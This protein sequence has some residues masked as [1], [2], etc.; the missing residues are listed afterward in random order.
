MAREHRRHHGQPAATSWKMRLAA[1]AGIAVTAGAAAFGVSR[2]VG[3]GVAAG[4]GVGWFGGYAF[5]ELSHWYAHHG[6]PRTS[7]GHRM[8]RRHFRH[9]FGAP[10]A[11]LGV[12]TSVWDRLAGTEVVEDGPVRVP[13]RLAMS[14]LV[15][16]H[17]EVR[18]EYRDDYVLAGRRSLDDGQR[19]DD[20][21]RAYA[22]RPPR[23]D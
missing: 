17:G 14:W 13:R 3:G 18:P 5:Y 6:R 9:H 21:R 20:L 7:W 23:L 4:L 1:Y 19:A 10:R 12:T 2:L 8:R 15:D 16:D 22:D 11:N